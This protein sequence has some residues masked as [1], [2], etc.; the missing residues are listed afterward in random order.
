MPVDNSVTTDLQIVSTSG[1]RLYAGDYVY[2][3]TGSMLYMFIIIAFSSH[4]LPWPCILLSSS[5]VSLSA[6]FF[7]LALLHCPTVLFCSLLSLFVSILLSFGLP[8]SFCLPKIS[9]RLCN[10][11]LFSS[12][13]FLVDFL[14][15]FLCLL[16]STNF[17]L[18]T[19]PVYYHSTG[20]PTLILM[21][22]NSWVKGPNSWVMGPNS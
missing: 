17:T 1:S 21:T 7:S 13:L 15:R 4:L 11:S 14:Q 12:P 10:S 2:I 16:Y 9:L 18:Q 3:I 6:S 8:S 5:S 19:L 20:L 22:P